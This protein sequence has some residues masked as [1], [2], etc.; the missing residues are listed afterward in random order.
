MTKKNYIKA[1]ELVKK[2]RIHNP[3]DAQVVEKTFV[4]FFQD[5]N[6]RFDEQRFISACK[7]EG[8]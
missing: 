1:S 8:F 5:D 2:I 3:M 6:P 7:N 4:N